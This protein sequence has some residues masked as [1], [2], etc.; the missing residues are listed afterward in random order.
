MLRLY[1]PAYTDGRKMTVPYLPLC[2]PRYFAPLAV[3]IMSQ[4]VDGELVITNDIFDQIAD[5]DDSDQLSLVN[6]GKMANSLLGHH[7]HA[8]FRS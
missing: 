1:H 7:R 2:A 5:R 8:F 4:L 6:D 3:Q